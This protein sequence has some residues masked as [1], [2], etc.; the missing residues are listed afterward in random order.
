[1]C[2]AAS[3]PAAATQPKRVP[4]PTN[5]CS[6]LL[7]RLTGQAVWA[8]RVCLAAST[9]AAAHTA[10]ARALPHPQVQRRPEEYDQVL[11]NCVASWGKVP[12]TPPPDHVALTPGTW[13]AVG[14]RVPCT[15]QRLHCPIWTAPVSHEGLNVPCT[16]QRLHCPIWTAPVS[17]EG[18]NACIV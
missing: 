1:M 11:Q 13:C 10:Q 17:L 7:R 15:L 8:G 16:L 18:L 12:Y 5:T 9:P 3:T 14:A 6:A 4:C 2:L